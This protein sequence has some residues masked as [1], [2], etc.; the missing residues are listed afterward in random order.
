MAR[1]TFST[2]A[3]SE[4][5]EIEINGEVFK[6]N[7]Q[8]PGDILLEFL[9]GAD[10]EDPS[11]MAKTIRNLL[12]NAVDPDDLDRFKAYIR[13]PKNNVNLTVLSEIAGYVTEVLSGG[14]DHRPLP[15]PSLS[16]L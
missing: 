8:V 9:A 4:T 6:L 16:G 12:D 14:N 15:A 5:Q 3:P 1:K 13:D 10:T 2:Y 11:G 7:A